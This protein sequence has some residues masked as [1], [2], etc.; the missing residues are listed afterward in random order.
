MGISIQRTELD[1]QDP[2]SQIYSW[3]GLPARGIRTPRDAFR[4]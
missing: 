3:F 4:R 2:A 1:R